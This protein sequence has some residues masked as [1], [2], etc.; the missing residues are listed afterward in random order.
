MR[1]RDPGGKHRINDERMIRVGLVGVWTAAVLL[2]GPTAGAQGVAGA[3][4]S[5]VDQ[6]GAVLPGATVTLHGPVTR[7]VVTGPDG[8]F[9][10]QNLPDGDYDVT[11]VLAGFT[12][13]ARRVHLTK[14][15]TVDLSAALVVQILEQVTVTADRT[16]DRDLQATP[17]AVTA[18]SGADLTRAQARTVEDVAGRVPS[19]TF[20][21]NTGLAQITIRGIGT[22][23]ALAGSDP[24]SAVY[25]DGV[26]LRA[27]PWR[28]PPFSI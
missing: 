28:W 17:M 27:R 14:G 1:T 22:N 21:Q 10:V 16:G 3:R 15:S 4:G 24:S 8:R 19:V 9:D 18:L 13:S 20:S 2:H 26:Y 23:V 12:P 11:V 5:V 7:V 6:S 25:L